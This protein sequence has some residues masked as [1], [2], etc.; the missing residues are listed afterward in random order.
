MDVTTVQIITAITGL[1]GALVG[2]LVT[3]A[4]AHAGERRRERAAA[5]V[6]GRLVVEAWANA[7]GSL[8]AD[9]RANQWWPY[10]MPLSVWPE[11]RDAIV[12]ELLEEEWMA[13][14]L[15][16]RSLEGLE[17]LRD[18]WSARATTPE[19]ARTEIDQFLSG[20]DTGTESL[21]RMVEDSRW[22]RRLPRRQVER[23]YELQD[24]LD[25]DG[26]LGDETVK[27]RRLSRGRR[28]RR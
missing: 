26:T 16:Q 20:V 13:T 15:A 5:R 23:I 10:T 27:R 3:W 2:G 1:S 9:L 12:G 22:R 25:P 21:R 6:A 7:S 4:A 8:R 18:L 11:R 24:A 28:R 17:Q 19:V 14:Y